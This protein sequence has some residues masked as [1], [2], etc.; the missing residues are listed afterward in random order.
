MTLPA[1]RR[2]VQRLPLVTVFLAAAC[3]RHL[4]PAPVPEAIVPRVAGVVPPEA[5]R[6]RL[7]V[8]V[9][10]GPVEVQ[11]VHM[12]SEQLTDDQGRARFALY[13]SPRPLCPL[14]PCVVELPPGNVL[15]G[16][17]ILG[18]SDGLEVELVHIA[19][20][21]TV[22]RRALTIF[23]SGAGPGRTLGIVSTSLGGTA[24]MTGTALLPIGLAKDMDGMT[25]AGAI[26]LGVGT[27]FLVL[28][29][30]AITNNPSIFRKGASNRFS[31]TF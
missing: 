19:P 27:A 25:L 4:P 7:V 28:G 24:M 31:L 16:F 2:V 29:I 22:Y 1:L 17:P 13:E 21:T 6:G 5:G 12:K 30:V 14:S 26:T 10:D 3:V 8:D 9:V 18:K 20:G 23:E 11:R 15:L